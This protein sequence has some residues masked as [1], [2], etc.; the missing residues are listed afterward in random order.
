MK[1]Y[2]IRHGQTEWNITGRI[3]GKTDILLNETGLYQAGLLSEAMAKRSIEA[4]FASPLKRASDTACAVA[5]KKRLPVTPVNELRE[6]DFGL[7]EGLTWDE[8]SKRYPADFAAW[9]EN[10]VK[11][12]PTGGE[13]KESSKARCKLAMDR[14][15]NSSDGDIA[16]VAHGGIL[17][18]VADYLLQA[19]K[20]RN[21]IIVRNASIT[22]IEYDRE[23][24]VGELLLLNDVGHLAKAVTK[25]T[26]KYC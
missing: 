17:V 2:L 26:N 23:S 6:V 22:I 1:L 13:K 11:N 19:K 21:E 18:F 7:W 10:P 12:T 3:Q 4:I 24:G 14:I 5:A 25:T 8:I 15:L 9:D 20:D 16:I